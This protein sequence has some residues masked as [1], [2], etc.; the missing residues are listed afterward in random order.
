MQR[1]VAWGGV[2][3]LSQWLCSARMLKFANGSLCKVWRIWWWRGARYDGANGS[4]L[5]C[6]Y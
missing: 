6:P 1:A 5:L 2:A 4:A 3:Y